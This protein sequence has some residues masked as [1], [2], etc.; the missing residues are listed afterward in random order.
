MSIGPGGVYKR[1]EKNFNE[2][3]KPMKFLEE[4]IFSNELIIPTPQYDDGLSLFTLK[5]VRNL[6]P[7]RPVG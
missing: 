3:G 2:K 7:G 5:E 1:K 6:S 4:F